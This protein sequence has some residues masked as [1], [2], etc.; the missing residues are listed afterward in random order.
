[1]LPLR[2]KQENYH[3]SERKIHSEVENKRKDSNLRV[4]FALR[5]D[6]SCSKQQS[7]ELEKLVN[8]Q[9]KDFSIDSRTSFPS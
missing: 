5:S 8:G 9:I 4:Y 7:V 1:M 3:S 6:F 2:I